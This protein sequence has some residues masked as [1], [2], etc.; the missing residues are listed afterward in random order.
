M[1]SLLAR[2]A[3][4]LCSRPRCTYVLARSAALMYSGVKLRLCARAFRC[5]YML[6]LTHCWARGTGGL[7]LKWI[8]HDDFIVLPTVQQSGVR[9]ENG[10]LRQVDHWKSKE[11]QNHLQLC[12]QQD[13]LNN[14]RSIQYYNKVND[15]NFIYLPFRLTGSLDVW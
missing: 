2:F 14:A 12:L 3:A 4:L 10:L 15:V 11:K 13:L 5:A 1:L 9:M 7:S 6:L 8:E